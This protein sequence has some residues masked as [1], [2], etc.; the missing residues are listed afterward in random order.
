MQ[1]KADYC[2]LILLFVECCYV[3]K[4]SSVFLNS[5]YSCRP[6]ERMQSVPNQNILNTGS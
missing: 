5:L 2:K 1:Q 4:F 6:P 3:Q